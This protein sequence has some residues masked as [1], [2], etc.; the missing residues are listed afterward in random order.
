MRSLACLSRFAVPFALLAGAL[1]LPAC[2][3][4]APPASA[5]AAAAPDAQA[6]PL[7]CG[8]AT[9]GARQYCEVRCTC[10]GVPTDQPPSADYTCRPIPAG[11][12]A[13]DLCGCPALTGQ[14]ACDPSARA[15]DIP[16][17]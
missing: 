16:C 6:T 12:S 10:C 2:G 5:D 4:D 14:G 13:D 11:C 9:C 3:G 15:I 1:W 7:S 8:S 17:A